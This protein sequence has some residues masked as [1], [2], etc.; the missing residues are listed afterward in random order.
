MCKHE[1]GLIGLK[2]MFLWV[3]ETLIIK[4][5][6]MYLHSMYVHSHIVSVCIECVCMY[7]QHGD[8]LK[9]MHNHG[10]NLYTL[11][12]RVASLAPPNIMRKSCIIIYIATLPY[13]PAVI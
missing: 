9:L 2:S 7:L 12:M 8:D 10:F 3:K 5:R 4:V 6:G 1:V 11:H 13:N